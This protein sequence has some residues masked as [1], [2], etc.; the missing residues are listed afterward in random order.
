MTQQ[1]YKAE[2]RRQL[3][4][5]AAREQERRTPHVVMPRW[6][7]V[8]AVVAAGVAAVLITLALIA[9]DQAGRTNERRV[10]GPRAQ[11]V[12]PLFGGTIDRGVRYRS[13]KLAV[14]VSF[15][16]HD[17]GWFADV[18]DQPGVIILERTP[19]HVTHSRSRQYLSIGVPGK[20]VD[21]HHGR[22]EP[23]PADPVR[24]IRRHPDLRVTRAARVTVGGRPA[25]MLD[26][27]VVFRTPVKH[28]R[29]CE[30]RYV[31]PFQPLNGPIIPCTT[32]APG[33]EVPRGMRITWLLLTAPD[34]TPLLIEFDAFP[35]GQY[36]R[37]L[38]KAVEL[39]G[40]LRFGR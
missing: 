28:G 24:W 31:S 19:A 21:P 26:T 39:L 17:D 33:F 35:V 13:R 29:G 10:S 25:T 40:T 38:P 2:L 11:R 36:Q 14:P 27:T 30:Q 9:A 34:G 3:V 7:T 20:V 15:V 37:L 6:Q 5:A 16:A 23:A 32:L 12:E 8:G 18:A 22:E 4:A 1:A